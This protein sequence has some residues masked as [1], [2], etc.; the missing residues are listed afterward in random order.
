MSE[1]KPSPAGDP[2]TNDLKLPAPSRFGSP[3]QARLRANLLDAQRRISALPDGTDARLLQRCR[4]CLQRATA[5]VAHD[6]YVAWDCLHQ[7]EDELL[8]TLSEDERRTRF[9]SMRAEASE[10]LA[11]TWREQA[12]DTLAKLVP[13]GQ[14]PS[15]NVL[16]ELHA[17]L[18]A[19]SQ[20]KHHKL[21]Q[22]ERRSLPWLAALLSLALLGAVSYSAWVLRYA[23]PGDSRLDWAHLLRL[24]VCAGAL[25]GI[26]SMAF[27]MGSLNLRA[28]IP[29]VHLS[30]LVALTRPLLGAA[31]AVP[32]LVLVNGQSIS[33]SNANLD[34]W[35]L[36]AA[37]CFL[38]GFSERWF[39]D[40]MKRVEGEKK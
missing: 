4:D 16:R 9:L 33:L 30:G 23:P 31:V 19:A 29:D 37:C 10:K 27:S 28:P 22:F 13:A 8:A 39:L 18:A 2:E 6:S 24:A 38:G 3:Q 7:I 35:K 26:L 34:G 32:I 5:S 20:N 15:L 12:A 17:H 25:G 36:V 1:P 21:D 11:S 14:A 40:L